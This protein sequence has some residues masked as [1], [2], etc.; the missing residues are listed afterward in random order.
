[1]EPAKFNLKKNIRKIGKLK[2]KS[3]RMESLKIEN[4]LFSGTQ[5]VWEKE[6]LIRMKKNGKKIILKK[7][8]IPSFLPCCYCNTH[9][10]TSPQINKIK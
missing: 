9:R 4:I 5:Q 2:E 1:M 10:T 8:K 7:E 3:R 6:A